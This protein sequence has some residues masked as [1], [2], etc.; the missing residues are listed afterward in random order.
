M[1]LWGTKRERKQR[2]NPAAAADGV[3]TTAQKY[4][5]KQG[6]WTPLSLWTDRKAGA[7]SGRNTSGEERC[8]NLLFIFHCLYSWAPK[9]EK[10][11][12]FWFLQFGT[13]FQS[14]LLSFCLHLSSLWGWKII[15]SW[16]SF[17]YFIT[18]STC[19]YWWFGHI[20][21]FLGKVP[22]L[23]TSVKY[24]WMYSTKFALYMFVLPIQ[25]VL[26]YSNGDVLYWMKV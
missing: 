1:A 16:F 19:L 8:V 23:F 5:R 11:A 15:Q 7:T 3:Q 18:S 21:L 25:F 13:I 2:E 20:F 24:E 17:S 22:F 9:I 14:F 6:I 4:D 10:K 12:Y 26:I